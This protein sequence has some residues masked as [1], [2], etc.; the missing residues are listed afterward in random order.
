[1]RVIS[2]SNSRPRSTFR[3]NGCADKNLYKKVTNKQTLLKTIVCI[4]NI[5]LNL[6]L[7]FI[8]ICRLTEFLFDELENIQSLFLFDED[9]FSLNFS[10]FYA[11]RLK[12]FFFFVFLSIF[13]SLFFCSF[14]FSLFSFLI[15]FPFSFLSSSNFLLIYTP[16]ISSLASFLSFFFFR[17]LCLLQCFHFSYYLLFFFSLTSFLFFSS[18][19]FNLFFYVFLFGRLSK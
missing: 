17:I 5:N 16:S 11:Q 10:C 9:F 12:L 1:M 18:S 13:S 14:L 2:T 15:A 7:S 19:L 6:M 8:Y 4:W 3:W